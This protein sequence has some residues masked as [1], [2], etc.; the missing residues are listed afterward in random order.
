MENWSGAS[1]AKVVTFGRSVS[2]DRNERA[3]HMFSNELLVAL[4][5]VNVAI[6]LKVCIIRRKNLEYCLVQH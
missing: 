2:L 5:V 4:Y 6:F 1:W 3:Q